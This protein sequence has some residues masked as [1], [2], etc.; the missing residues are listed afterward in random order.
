MKTDSQYTHMGMRDLTHAEQFELVTK[1]DSIDLMSGQA[2]P[3]VA[4][5]TVE[6]LLK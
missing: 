4:N 6:D 5:K 2:T 3:V 1:H